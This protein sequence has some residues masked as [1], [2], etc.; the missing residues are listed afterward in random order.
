MANVLTSCCMNAGNNAWVVMNNKL[1]GITDITNTSAAW[2]LL[3]TPGP[4]IQ[5]TCGTRYSSSVGIITSDNN[6]WIATINI[7]T[8]PTWKYTGVK[9]KWF[10]LWSNGIEFTY[11]GLDNEQYR[12]R[13]KSVKLPRPKSGA[14]PIAI[15]DYCISFN[16]WGTFLGNDGKIYYDSNM[17]GGD[18]NAANWWTALIINVPRATSYAQQDNAVLWVVQNGT[19][20]FTEN[21]RAKDGGFIKVK[22]VGQVK[23][24]SA[25]NNRNFIAITTDNKVVWGNYDQTK[26][27]QMNNLIDLYVT[28]PAFITSNKYASLT[29][30]LSNPRIKDINTLNNGPASYIQRM[31]KSGVTDFTPFKLLT[32]NDLVNIGKASIVTYTDPNFE[33][34][35]FNVWVMTFDTDDPYLPLGDV[36]VSA[37]ADINQVLCVLVK[38]T[39]E[40]STLVKTSDYKE[41]GHSWDRHDRGSGYTYNTLTKAT[42]LPSNQYTLF[43]A[44]TNTKTREYKNTGFYLIGDVVTGGN[45]G[46]GAGPLSGNIPYFRSIYGLAGN[47]IIVSGVSIQNVN[48]TGKSSDQLK[49]N[50]NSRV[51][52]FVAVNPQYLTVKS[53]MDPLS[54]SFM[55]SYKPGNNMKAYWKLYNTTP[56]NTFAIS[57]GGEPNNPPVGFQY[58][59]FLPSYLVA[60][61]CGNGKAK[62]DMGFTN[63]ISP[64]AAVNCQAWMDTYMKINN[65]E[66]IKKTPVSDWCG[67]A[68]SQCD[69][70]LSVF[71][72]MGPN[73]KLYTKKDAAGVPSAQLPM[74]TTKQKLLAA[75][76][77][78]TLGMCG[79]FMPSDYSIGIDY[80]ELIDGKMKPKD[81]A[82]FM[83]LSIAAKAYQIPG[84]FDSSCANNK[85]NRQA[86][87]N[88]PG[89][90]RAVQICMNKSIIENAGTITGNINVKQDNNCQST[91]V[92]AAPTSKPASSNAAPTSTSATTKDTTIVN[93]KQL[94]LN[95]G[96]F[97]NK[98]KY[99][100]DVNIA[101]ENKAEQVVIAAKVD[102]AIAIKA[103]EE[104][105][106][107]ANAE[108]E[109][110]AK[111]RADELKKAKELADAQ[112]KKQLESQGP[113]IVQPVVKSNVTLYI[114]IAI[115]VMLLLGGGAFLLLKK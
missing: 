105:K 26:A 43:S 92:N 64:V 108:A 27:L 6:V 70:N 102:P 11:I 30:S 67:Q 48:T 54:A 33:G 21:Y 50:T 94:N 112:T 93:A 72:T 98:G 79:C 17:Y 82:E 63:S 104:R 51:R 87:K 38:N 13:G 1:Y 71:C 22:D 19:L 96:S 74:S 99:T 68:G 86:W 32:L 18:P 95:T 45:Q 16:S 14:Y 8:S 35:G 2:N 5:V 107:K 46:N 101:K 65:Y 15:N 24:V 58:V 34:K 10:N 91:V 39:S 47:F 97:E 83:N 37:N 12:Y 20:N 80:N 42:N 100:G 3:S 49:I 90:C 89:G 61:I 88:A 113:N 36:I 25:G 56:F 77:N 44:T 55:D 29:N 75:Y 84:C 69:D 31:A 52:P 60:S 78:S 81:A 9:A 62:T 40:Y 85:V 66:N 110:L 41:L 23:A 73:G 4:V 115:I 76:P 106:K 109:K 103:E 111:Q 28:I 59:D 53:E 57:P 7:L 114:I